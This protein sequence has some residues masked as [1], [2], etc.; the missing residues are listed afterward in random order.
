MPDNGLAADIV[1]TGTLNGW[2][3]LDDDGDNAAH[4]RRLSPAVYAAMLSCRAATACA[5]A[6]AERD[7]SNLQQP[8]YL[9]RRP[10]ATPWRTGSSSTVKEFKLSRPPS[11]QKKRKASDHK[12]GK[13]AT[14][15]PLSTDIAATAASAA[16]LPR[17]PSSSAINR[18]VSLNQNGIRRRDDAT[19]QPGRR[20]LS[21]RQRY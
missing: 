10:L 16:T 15:E 21:A 18:E 13:V 8:R 20:Y 2:T 9:H 5:L 4:M 6:S 11:T 7:G 1:G 12:R 3:V 19:P 14:P 17:L